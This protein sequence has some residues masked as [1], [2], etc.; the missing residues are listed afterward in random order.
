MG[1]DARV[2]RGGRLE[3][4]TYRIE[5]DL[6]VRAHGARVR[7][8]L[9]FGWNEPGTGTLVDLDLASAVRVTLNGRHLP[10][11]A[12]D[13]RQVELDDLAAENVLTVVSELDYSVG[14]HGVCSVTG[15]GDR[16]VYL[17]LGPST[18]APVLPCFF[19][20]GPT[21]V[22]LRVRAP[23]GW[24][25]T[26]H[27]APIT[28]PRP[29]SAGEWHFLVSL[30]LDAR[31][32]AFAAGPWAEVHGPARS[33][34]PRVVSTLF[35]PRGSADLL[36]ASSI[37]DDLPR[38]LDHLERL[39]GIP[40][41]YGQA[42]CV[43]IPD[44]GSQGTLNCGLWLLHERVL[45]ASAD[46]GWRRYVLWV[47]AHEAAHAW[48]GGLVLEGEPQDLWL[49]EGIATYLCHRALAVLLPASAPWA[50]FHLLEEREAH[51]ADETSDHPVANWTADAPTRSAPPSLIYAKPAAVI[52]H[53]G[54]LIGVRAVDAGL[55][56]FVTR[57]A[58]TAPTTTDV[59]RCWEA[60]AG[61]DLQ[62][63]ANDW[64]MTPGVNTL[65]LVLETSPQD[66]VRTA[67][68]VQSPG[69]GGRL[70]THR[71][72]VQAFDRTPD[73][74][75]ARRS[76]VDVTVVGQA[77]PLRPLM[78]SPAPA[79][80]VL[81]APAT[82]Y[83]KVRLDERSRAAL[84]TSLSDLDADA[85]AACWVAGLEMVADDLIPPSE[86]QEWFARHRLADT[87]PQILR[88]LARATTA[89]DR[90]E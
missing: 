32:L 80:V 65:E 72:L 22:D 1:H 39:L 50:A 58:N 15:H 20:A 88:E 5:F 40:Y 64:L 30:P 31:M 2:D 49:L 52:R 3:A 85:R 62:E 60:A 7:T 8:E 41:P 84:A 44:Y 45:Q 74:Q 37:P 35:G 38:V 12:A 43:V 47:L 25:V 9:S 55:R 59:I 6:T 53:L 69:N 73:G 36:R 21:A 86:I 33:S 54:A 82:T 79:L 68:I 56:S 81:N 28:R 67:T 87:D 83:A 90:R 75:L 10:T 76:P 63:W 66:I 4:I 34:R 18:A 89:A 78:G 13:G 46:A 16:Y 42:D 24:S 57:H 27:T 14:G 29:G 77:T 70:R 11:D 23:A 48:F 19:R 71:L 26:S 17:S 51:E 61:R